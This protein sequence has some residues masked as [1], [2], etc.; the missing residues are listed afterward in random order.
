M[1]VEIVTFRIFTLQL[2]EALLAETQ[3]DWRLSLQND[4][5]LLGAAPHG[6]E[7]FPQMWCHQLFP[8]VLTQ[9]CT[10]IPYVQS[11]DSNCTSLILPQPPL[12]FP[13]TFANRNLV[14]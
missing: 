7:S 11:D 3:G 14:E 1:N 12:T 5:V 10:D 6:E 2:A 8:N 13:D 4:R 9:S